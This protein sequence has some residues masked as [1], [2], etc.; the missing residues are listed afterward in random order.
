MKKDKI[1]RS[2]MKRLKV[3]NK[4][5]WNHIFYRNN[6]YLCPNKFY[7]DKCIVV[8]KTEYMGKTKKTN[9][10]KRRNKIQNRTSG[11]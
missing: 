8:F 11:Y 6:D 5:D 9:I 1:L 10:Y 2:N 4:S 7:D 3:K